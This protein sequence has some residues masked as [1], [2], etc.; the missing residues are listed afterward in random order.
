MRTYLRLDD[1]QKLPNNTAVATFSMKV[2]GQIC[3][4]TGML[5]GGAASMI[6]DMCTTLAQAP[7]A[8]PG[9]WEFGGVSRVLSVTYLRPIPKDS[10]ILIICEVVQVGKAL[11]TI[12]ARIYR[13]DGMVLLATGEHNKAAVDL[14]KRPSSL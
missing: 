6:I 11:V 14:K 4:R 8:R 7:I 3:N 5:H 2:V 9:Y 12:Q 13:K 1:A 10:E